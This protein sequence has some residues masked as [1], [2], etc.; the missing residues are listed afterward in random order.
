MDYRFGGLRGGGMDSLGV[1]RSESVGLSH[2][3]LPWRIRSLALVESEGVEKSVGLAD[4]ETA[5]RSSI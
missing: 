1:A 4:T 3:H 2:F 5:V